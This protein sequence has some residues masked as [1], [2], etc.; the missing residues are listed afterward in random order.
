MK[1]SLSLWFSADGWLRW[2]MVLAASVVAVCG[3]PNEAR[4]LTSWTT[5]PY[6]TSA[7]N[8]PPVP[9][10]QNTL[11]QFVRVSVGGE[12]VRF[13][14][15]NAYGTSP[16]VIRSAHLA[17]AAG[18]VGSGAINSASSRAFRFQGAPGTV[19]PPGGVIYSDPLSFGLPALAVVGVS[20]HYGAVSSTVISGHAGSRGTSFIQAGDAT[21]SATLPGATATER[22]YTITGL[23][24]L[25]PKGQGGLV[26][27]IGDS[28]TDGRG[29]TTN[30]NNRWTDFLAQRLAANPATAYVGVGNLGIGATGIGLAQERFRRD[31]LE[32]PGAR[33]VI[34]FI[35]VNDIGG[36]NAAPATIVG[37]LVNAY[38][39][40]ANQ[41]KTRGLK[42]YGATITP[43]GG[44]G[45]YS[46]NRETARQSINTWIR[47][48]AIEAGIFDACLDFDAAVRDPG[49]PINLLPA[50]NADN[51]HI[52]PAGY[53]AMAEAVD[54][55]LFTP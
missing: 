6:L 27:A 29:S 33:W 17:L 54:L 23:E 55:S 50:Y 2:F 31:V 48:T 52:T 5:A 13:R 44:S 15:S 16:V 38:T 30:G 25:A 36:S 47:E 14:F 3:A 20:I 40:M 4:W 19:I 32:Q 42:V 1:R 9:L 11:R 39:T 21:L 26:A 49:N 10:A 34:I 12:V 8:L 46:V 37:N 18:V 28:I 7:E 24:V 41:A 43:F 35:G 45:Y 22:W 51:L 53:A